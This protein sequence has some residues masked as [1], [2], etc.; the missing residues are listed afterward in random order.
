MQPQTIACLMPSFGLWKLKQRKPHSELQK[1]E[2]VFPSYWVQLG[3][4]IWGRFQQTWTG[5][6][7]CF[8]L[9]SFCFC[10]H[11]IAES[12]QMSFHISCSIDKWPCC[13]ALRCDMRCLEMFWVSG[14][15][16]FKKISFLAAT[17]PAAWHKEH[18]CPT[19]TPCRS[20]NWCSLRLRVRT[21]QFDLGV[22]TG[23]NMQPL[24][25]FFWKVKFLDSRQF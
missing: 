19:V 15:I 10:S 1:Y 25:S 11:S 12:F 17:H 24:H 21:V 4:W 18:G 9:I 6:P 8:S 14:I 7:F 13:R 20:L 16:F 23:K 22:F 2:V 3:T 5:M